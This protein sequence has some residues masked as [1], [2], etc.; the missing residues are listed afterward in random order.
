MFLPSLEVLNLDW[1]EKLEHFP[2]IENKMIKPL[3]IHMIGT[4]IKKLPNSV[5]NLT[6]LVSM[7]MQY[8]EN[9]EYLPS[10]LF[11]L[12]NV[13]AFDFGGCSKLGESFK[14]F[15]P[16]SPSTL[17]K[18]HFEESGLSDE[19]MQAILICFPKLE[20]L[21]V[22][23]NNLVSLPACIK[24]SAHLANLDVSDCKKLKEI[25]ECTNL[26]IMNVHGCMSLAH[27]SELPCTIKKVDA[28]KCFNFSSETSNM[29]W[30]QVHNIYIACPKLFDVFIL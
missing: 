15:L 23:K 26:R 24:E 17:K 9:L 14:R 20:E 2:E 19:D 27:I 6:G 4:S 3:K 11:E 16:H 5:G 22:Y 29:L 7:D 1:C 21:I 18:L 28:R 30:D 25:P 12:P 13:V 8:S 10:S